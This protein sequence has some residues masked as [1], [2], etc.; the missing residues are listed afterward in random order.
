[1]LRFK[2]ELTLETPESGQGEELGLAP[3]AR[4]S[5]GPPPPHHRLHKPPALF[6]EGSI[7]G[8]GSRHYS[9]PPPGSH[10]LTV[11]AQTKEWVI[12]APQG[13]SGLKVGIRIPAPTQP[14]QNDFV[15]A[16]LS[17][18]VLTCNP[19]QNRHCPA[20]SSLDHPLAGKNWGFQGN[21]Q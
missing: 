15:P 8:R 1:M 2:T 20:H 10:L 9:S 17:L 18:H 19:D 16:P 3:R 5:P 7:P 21:C 13:L 4:P 11:S 12:A 6:T 14:Q